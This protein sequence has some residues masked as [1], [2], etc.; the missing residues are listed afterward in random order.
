MIFD[1]IDPKTQYMRTITQE[2]KSPESIGRQI[3]D[4]IASGG[5]A[6]IPCAGH[7]RIIADLHNP[8]AVIAL[9][10]FKRRAKRAPA[11]VFIADAAQLDSLT[12][13]L[14]PMTKRIAET[15][16]PEPVT[17]RIDPSTLPRLVRK[18]LGG[19]KIRLGVRVPNDKIMQEILK[20]IGRPLLVSS[21]NREK[22]A[23][24]TSV[25]QIKQTF[26]NKVDIFLDRG[27]L[28]AL[29]A[30]TVV[31]IVNGKVKI[32]RQGSVAEERIVSAANGTL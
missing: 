20:T 24:D 18:Q 19:N 29:P 26:G 16:W 6:C 10:M 1:A 12:E 21:A 4:V 3:S 9:M 7:Y 8:D 23:G 28:Q 5:V 14:H 17:L 11:L 30:S 32:E 2:G 25:A 27:D 13:E 31:D 15:L 22:K